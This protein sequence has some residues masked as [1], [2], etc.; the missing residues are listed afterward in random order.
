MVCRGS[1]GGVRPVVCAVVIRSFLAVVP[2]LS[3]VLCFWLKPG[4]S[5]AF[6]AEVVSKTC[7]PPQTLC[8]EDVTATRCHQNKSVSRLMRC[9]WLPC[10]MSSRATIGPGRIHTV[11]GADA[12]DL[13]GDLV[14]PADSSL[15]SVWESCGQRN[16]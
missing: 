14:A 2:A 16:Q 1:D 12:V 9:W 15:R 4:S 8:G 10:A 5:G 3:V 13:V 6:T 11:L 7:A